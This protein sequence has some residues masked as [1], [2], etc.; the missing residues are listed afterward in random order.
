MKR[1]GD[2]VISIRHSLD[3]LEQREERERLLLERQGLVLNCYASAIQSIR[4]YALEIDPDLAAKFRERLKELEGDLERASRP[5]DYQALESSLNGELRQYRDR[6]Q[7]LVI[8]LRSEV[9]DAA[10][11]MQALTDA[12]EAH[13]AGYETELRQELETLEAAAAMDHLPTVQST[14]RKTTAAIQ[15][16]FE[17][18]QR[19][20]QLVIA[21]LQDEIR[22]LHKAIETERR[23]QYI[24]G[25]TGVWNRRKLAERMDDLL[26]RDES[27]ALLL[28]AV[29]NWRDVERR[30]SQAAADR[31][32]KSLVTRLVEKF[33]AEGMVGRWNDDMLAVI[34]ETDP[35]AAATLAEGTDQELGS[36][37]SASSE[38]QL[39]GLA[40][41]IRSA[42]IGRPRGTHAADF[43]PKIG[44]QVSILAD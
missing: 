31:I 13:G 19:S 44:Q 22:G 17:Q 35:V 7:A 20:N 25:A 3:E 29:A 14:I 2:G 42:L 34:V 41:K 37:Y 28:I 15:G 11:T 21:Q 38:D 8:R 36:G 24:D 16:S 9:A 18:M 10:A 1:S 27:F 33:G 39:P 12:V 32:L 40:L 30:H 26:K 5:Q 23:A 6:G 4:Q 43:Y